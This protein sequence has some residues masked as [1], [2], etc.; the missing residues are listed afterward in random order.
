MADVTPILPDMGAPLETA[1]PARPPQLHEA[2][3]LAN[4]AREQLIAAI[5]ATDADS[6]L[7]AQLNEA[8][9]DLESAIG[10]M[11]AVPEIEYLGQ[12]VH[13]RDV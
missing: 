11:T 3:R 6:D 7:E 8:C 5:E 13:R 4:E 1:I 10:Y 2:V 12:H 9:D